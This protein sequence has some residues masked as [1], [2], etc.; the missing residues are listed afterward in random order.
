MSMQ[1]PYLMP[2]GAPPNHPHRGP[3]ILSPVGACIGMVGALV[4]IIGSYGP[5]L[6]VSVMWGR[7]EIPGLG[8]VAS[9]GLG[10]PGPGLVPVICA[11]V[12]LCCLSLGAF[13]PQLS[14][15][16]WPPILALVLGLVTAVVSL[17]NAGNLHNLANSGSQFLEPFPVSELVKVDLG[18]GVVILFIGVLTLMV[19]AG[20]QLAVILRAIGSVSAGMTPFPSGMQVQGMPQHYGNV[21]PEQPAHPF[22]PY[23]QPAQPDPQRARP[24]TQSPQSYKY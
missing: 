15:Q 11:I 1:P 7:I 17:S 19:G 13:V 3:G 23:H 20:T 4:V 18:W 6:S 5:W 12:A 22:Q 21:I 8:G 16:P 2:Y 24:Y 9:L 14:A 10:S